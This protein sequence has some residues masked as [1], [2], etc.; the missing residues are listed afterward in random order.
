MLEFRWLVPPYPK[1]LNYQK[2]YETKEISDYW[3][4]LVVSPQSNQSK[5]ESEGLHVRPE[6]YE[7]YM[8][9]H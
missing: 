5:R 7:D 3:C 4:T 1:V 6:L 9:L 8:M 2:F